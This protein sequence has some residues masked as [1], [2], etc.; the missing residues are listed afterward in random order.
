MSIRPCNKE[1][2]EQCEIIFNLPELASASGSNLS[3]GYLKNFI[4]D[5]YFLVATNKKQIIG[6]IYGESLKAGGVMMWALAVDSQFQE[7][8]IGSKLLKAF[9]KNARA[10]KKSWVIL[11]A[12][13]ITKA[14][15]SFYKKHGYDI[16][17]TYIECAKDLK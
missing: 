9:E 7:Q 1:D 3:A 11:H 13:T 4:N 16:G 17:N 14:S 8:G 2:L 15:V 6:A 10:H 5:K 12:S